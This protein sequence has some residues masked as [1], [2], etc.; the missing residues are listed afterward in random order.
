MKTAMGKGKT[1]IRA[2]KSIPERIPMF[3]KGAKLA[4][5]IQASSTR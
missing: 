5:D 2:L 1:G 4:D 3:P